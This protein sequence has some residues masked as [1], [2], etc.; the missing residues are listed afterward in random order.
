[1]KEFVCRWGSFGEIETL[2]DIPLPTQHSRI[3]IMTHFVQLFFSIRSYTIICKELL[4]IFFGIQ[5]YF[6]N[7]Y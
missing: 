1:M 7:S 5:K 2:I 4:N 3:E 6:H